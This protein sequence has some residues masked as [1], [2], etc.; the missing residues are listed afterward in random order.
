MVVCWNRYGSW[1]TLDTQLQPVNQDHKKGWLP[2]TPKG[3]TAKQL[4]KG[5]NAQKDPKGTRGTLGF[6]PPLAF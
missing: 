3:P 2:H 4:P 5:N 6:E 1:W